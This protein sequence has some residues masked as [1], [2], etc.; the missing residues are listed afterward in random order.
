MK[1]EPIPKSFQIFGFMVVKWQNQTNKQ[2]SPK[3][4][5]KYVVQEI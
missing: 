2:T 4:E 1:H 3:L 5:R